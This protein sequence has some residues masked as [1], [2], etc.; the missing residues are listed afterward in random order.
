H[1]EHSASVSHRVRGVSAGAA[2]GP[3]ARTVAATVIARVLSDKAFAAAAL[4]A[5][6]DRAVQLE[7]RDRALAT[8]LVYG[9]LRLLGWLEARV[10]RH[11][12]RGSRTLDPLV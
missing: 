11:A 10:D 3:N 12:K 7:S 9:T 2:R 1:D 4:D 6:L 8:E 5:E